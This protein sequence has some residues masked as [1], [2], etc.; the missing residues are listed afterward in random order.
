MYPDADD[1]RGFLASLE[2]DLKRK[3][4][5]FRGTIET[6][7]RSG[8]LFFFDVALDARSPGVGDDGVLETFTLGQAYDNGLLN[9]TVHPGDERANAGRPVYEVWYVG[10]FGQKVTL[11]SDWYPEVVQ[12]APADPLVTSADPQGDAI[13]LVLQNKAERDAQTPAKTQAELETALN[14]SRA[15]QGDDASP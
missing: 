13:R 5:R 15:L 1:S 9:F 14:L 6:R 11:V 2:L 7:V 12:P 10:E 8:R 3:D 4:A